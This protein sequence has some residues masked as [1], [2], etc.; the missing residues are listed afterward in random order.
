M[1]NY[2]KIRMDRPDG[3]LIHLPN[4]RHKTQGFNTFRSSS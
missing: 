2:K 3:L 1:S 4:V